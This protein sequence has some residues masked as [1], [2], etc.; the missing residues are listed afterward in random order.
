M[1][2]TH[3]QSRHK[4]RFN[5]TILSGIM[6]S[7][8]FAAMIGF[9][10][11]GKAQE[12]ASEDAATTDITVGYRVTPPF[13][14]KDA[15]GNLTGMAID[16]W[17]EIEDG[18]GYAPTY[19]EYA[20]MADLVS[21]TAAKEVDVAV[22]AMSI[23]EERAMEIDF[24]QPWFDSGLRVMVD[25]YSSSSMTNL[26]DGLAESGHLQ[27]Y[28][29]LIL[30]VIVATIGLTLFDRHFDKNF[31]KRWREGIAE[32]FYA[33]MLV[34]TKG[35]L[36]SRAKLFGWYGRIFSAFWLVIGIAVLAYVTSSLTSV[37]TSIAVQGAIGGPDDLPG[38]VVGVLKGSTA[39][40]AMK[41]D[42]IEYVTYASVDDAITALRDNEV[43]AIVGDS[44]VLEYHKFIDP[45]PGLDIVGRIFSPDKYG[46]AVPYDE[47]S[48][49][50]PITV[51]LL[52]LQ[53]DGVVEDLAEK[54]FGDER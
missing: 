18:M 50:F 38:R 19:R 22:G 27:H 49:I 10:G 21:A 46:F 53:E 41:Q 6:L 11:A 30:L 29:I 7:L 44:P 36:P 17:N 5:T 15:D 34:V 26:W 33:V 16:L 13:V 40:T 9:A 2:H 32:S 12:T 37:M 1:F 23:T 42:E 54:Y 8:L 20:S 51:K 35:S 14:M 4:H 43:D 48:Q 45:K 28:G 52:S 31:P 47:S 24:T 39:E 25:N 3:V